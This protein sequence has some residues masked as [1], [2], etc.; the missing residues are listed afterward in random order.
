MHRGLE[1]HLDFWLDEARACGWTDAPPAAMPTPDALE[2][3]LSDAGNALLYEG[4]RT[5][6]YGTG[7][8]RSELMFVGEGPGRLTSGHAVPVMGPAGELL[9]RMIEQGMKRPRASVSL[10]NVVCT[11]AGQAPVDASEC[12][13]FLRAHIEAL[14]PRVV[15][16][17]GPEVLRGFY[18]EAA[19]TTPNRGAWLEVAG[20]AVMP[21]FHPSY[22]LAQPE[23]KRAAWT[24]LKQVMERLGW[25]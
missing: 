20:R 19:G 18:P 21:T 1:R 8:P 9:S 23:A 11:A 17:L 10:V 6:V 2:G 3:L 16:F 15:V 5:R 13:P 24:D 25:S 14:A 22:L 4:R 7:N 12:F